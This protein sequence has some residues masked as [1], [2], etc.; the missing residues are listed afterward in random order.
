VWLLFLYSL[1]FY[2]GILGEISSILEKFFLGIF[3][4]MFLIIF[5]QCP[6]GI[7]GVVFSSIGL[8]R[9]RKGYGNKGLA[10]AGLA[11]WVI[12]II[13]LI[14]TVAGVVTDIVQWWD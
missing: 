1:G 5:V 9:V 4:T 2:D 13:A 14:V 6:S 11:L 3:G 7:L 8:V 10:I 12:A